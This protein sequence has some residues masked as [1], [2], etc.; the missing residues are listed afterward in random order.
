MNAQ[1]KIIVV[2]DDVFMREMVA[3]VLSPGYTIMAAESATE[4][5]VL[6]GRDAP[7]LIILD[8]EMPETDG[9]EA[10]VTFKRHAQLADVPIIFLS[11][12]DQIEERLKGYEVGG[13]DYIVK[14]FAPEELKAKITHLLAMNADRNSLRE[15][16]D[17]AT[18]A[19]MTAITSMGE[20]GALLQSLK[21]FN[22]SADAQALAQAILEGIQAYGLSG[23]VQIRMPEGETTISDRGEVSPL[24]LSVINHLSGMDR[25]VQ[26]KTR[27]SIHYPHILILINNM[28]VE[29]ADRCG[30]LRDHLAMLVEAAEMRILGLI[31]EGQSRVRGAVIERTTERILNLLREIDAAQRQNRLEIRVASTDLIED[32]NKGLGEVALTNQQED[33]LSSIVVKGIEKIINIQSAEADMQDRLSGIVLDL[34]AILEV[35]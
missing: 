11:A 20:M 21:N 27:L 8:V 25:I 34:K 1:A 3:E 12:H 5:L 24:E 2:D 35:R 32:M 28:P 31:S 16:A 22:A 19:A 14:P 18:S 9:Y 23:T 13:E 29:D 6:A 10:C 4:A 33:Y 15:R 17:Y 7:D 26:F 30:R